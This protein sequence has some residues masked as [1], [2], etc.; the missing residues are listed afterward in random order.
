[1]NKV[2]ISRIE[3][4]NFKNVRLGVVDFSKESHKYAASILGLY[5]QNGSGKTALVEA[6]G[7]LKH[8]LSAVPLSM[9]AEAVPWWDLISVDSD[10]ATLGFRF[11]VDDEVLGSGCEVD[12]RF[13]IRPRRLE[14]PPGANAEKNGPVKMDIF[15]ETLSFSY[16]TESSRKSRLQ[17]YIDTTECDT[18]KPDSKYRLFAGSDKKIFADLVVEKRLALETSRSYIFSPVFYDIISRSASVKDGNVDAPQDIR[19]C[20]TVLRRLREFGTHNLMVVQGSAFSL[21][22][23]NMMPLSFAYASEKGRTSGTVLLPFKGPTLLPKHLFEVVSNVLGEMN[24]VLGQLVPGL[25]ISIREIG[26]RL[27]QDGSIGID[28]ELVSHKNSRPIP[29]RNESEGIRKIISVLHLLIEVYNNPT[30]TA[31]IDELDSGIFEYLLGELL[32]IVSER[33]RGQLIFTSHNLRPL[34]TL[35]K[36]FIA[37]T[38]TNPDNRYIRLR[39]V[40]PSNNLRDF[41]YREII[42]GGQNEKIYE[43]TSNAKI[44]FAFAQAGDNIYNAY[45]REAGH[46]S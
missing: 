23:L 21:L 35:D 34:E 7:L 28:A 5:G 12:Y 27:M 2:R 42:I 6:L 44:A 41:C 10:F 1:M 40:K 26:Q 36:D 37:F 29:L 3:L 30:V 22:N 19:A 14:L 33:G 25:T 39:N 32:K 13:S 11:L 45:G 17:T 4:Q 8:S 15:N 9:I 24:I 43:S 31:V 20:L 46:E 38:T 18:F 16:T